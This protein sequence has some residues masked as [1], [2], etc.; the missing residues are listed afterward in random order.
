MP[1]PKGY[2]ADTAL[3]RS[4][5]A[6]WH[7]G[8]ARTTVRTLTEAMGV[9]PR[10]LYQEFGD[11]DAVFVLSLE[12]YAQQNRRFYERRLGTE[13]YGLAALRVYFE[14]IRYEEDFKGCFLVNSLAELEILP[15]DAQAV[16][17]D[18]YAWVQKLYRRHVEAAVQAGAAAAETDV[19][20]LSTALMVF[21]QGLAVMGKTPAQRKNLARAA[22]ALLDAVMAD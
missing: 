6:F 22:T 20:G 3:D 7:T 1:R 16:V 13:P 5:E 10:S 9:P 8:Y 4:I 11:K 18:F 19:D 2:N 17:E 12:R 21:D 14:G 15:Q